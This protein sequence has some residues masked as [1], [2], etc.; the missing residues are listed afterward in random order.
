MRQR[1][2]YLRWFRSAAAE[3]IRCGEQLPQPSEPTACRSRS[4]RFA[5]GPGSGNSARLTSPRSRDA[6]YFRG[7]GQAGAAF[8]DS[9]C[10]HRGHSGADRPLIDLQ[11]IGLFPDQFANVVGEYKNLE[12]AQPAAIACT[13]A[14]LAAAGP[15]KRF[16]APE[17]ER[18]HPGVFG[19]TVLDERL[20]HFAAV[21]QLA[22]KP[23]CDHCSQG[24]PQQISLDAKIEETGHRGSRDR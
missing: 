17:A 15:L 22:N 21:A 6:E 4:L 18:A 1:L 20:G 24:G 23:L 14:A 8:R 10:E 13:T 3:D 2:P 12:H 19:K 5:S 7:R 9:L 11:S 16:A